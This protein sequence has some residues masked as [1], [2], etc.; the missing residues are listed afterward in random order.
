MFKNPKLRSKSLKLKSSPGCINKALN[1]VI[2]FVQN[3]FR[4]PHLKIKPSAYYDLKTVNLNSEL[5]NEEI[6]SERI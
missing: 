6:K 3:L 1:F 4:Y 2:L 5:V